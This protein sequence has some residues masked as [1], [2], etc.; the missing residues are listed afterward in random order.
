MRIT[1]IRNIT[2]QNNNS[3][4][5]AGKVNKNSSKGANTALGLTSL[6]GLGTAAYLVL[7]KPDALKR[8]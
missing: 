2:F 1:G 7:R 5:E 4:Q 3:K 8:A 6:A